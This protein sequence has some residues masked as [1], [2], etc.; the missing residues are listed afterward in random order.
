[1]EME[2]SEVSRIFNNEEFGYWAITVERPLRLR[3]FPENHIPDSVFRNADER[4]EYEQ[5]IKK[6]SKN[7][8]L[9][10]WTAFAKPK[11]LNPAIVKNVRSYITE[12]DP[13]AQP[14]EESLTLTCATRKSCLLPMMAVLK[15]S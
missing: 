8:P 2:K 4:A 11:K 14:V 6:L 5:A 10:D 1:M 3:I 7:A 15:L 9:D 13:S 12:K